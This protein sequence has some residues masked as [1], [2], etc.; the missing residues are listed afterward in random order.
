MGCCNGISQYAQGEKGQA[1][2]FNDRTDRIRITTHAAEQYRK[3]IDRMI[4][5]NEVVSLLTERA[6]CAA[7]LKDKT[8]LG[9]EQWRIDEPYPCVLVIKRD[10]DQPIVAVVVTVLEIERPPDDLDMR[11]FA[12]ETPFAPMTRKRK[13]QRSRRRRPRF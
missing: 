10:R 4:P 6:A 13:Q 9:H 11:E 1:G 3:R 2:M 12:S 5:M 7:H 8:L